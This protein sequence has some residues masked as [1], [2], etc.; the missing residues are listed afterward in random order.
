MPSRYVTIQGVMTWDEPTTPPVQPPVIWPGPHPSHP[1]MLP[2]MP[3]WG[4]GAQP[5]GPVDPGYSPP[6]AQVR[7]PVDPGYS[8]PWAQVRP[9]TAGWPGVPSLPNVPPFPP[10]PTHPIMLPGMP[11]F[12]G[13]PGF[14]GP[15]GGPPIGPGHPDYPTRPHPQPP[16]G[17]G[18]PGGGGPPEAPAFE[19]IGEPG[20]VLSY[21]W[22]YSPIYGWVV[23]VP[24]SAST[25]PVPPAGPDIGAPEPPIPTEPPPE[26][27]EK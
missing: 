12:G 8:P 21:Q 4:S 15:G 19:P 17:G 26:P 25:G 18:W 11:G 20:P 16:P 1:I 13:I 2:G 23:G 24:P 5:P 10:V 9:P 22:Y 3:G 27:E 14:G 7:P 6:W